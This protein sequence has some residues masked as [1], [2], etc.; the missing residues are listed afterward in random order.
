M[1]ALVLEDERHARSYL[2]ELIEATGLAHVNAAVATVALANA[3]LIDDQ[4]D[5]AFVDVRLVGTAAMDTAGL[6]WIEEIRRLASPPQIIVTTASSEHAVTAFELGAVDYLLK[7]FL[8]KRVA[9]SLERARSRHR[10][11]NLGV[12]RLRPRVV[13]RKGRGLVFLEPDEAWAFEAEGRLCYVHS[14]EGRFD[15]DLS[16]AALEAVLGESFL[17]VHR[18]WLVSLSHVRE[19]DRAD[20][21]PTLLL[22]ESATRRT[23]RVQVARERTTLVRERLLDSTVG[24]RRDE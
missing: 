8:Q 11:P 16:L 21:L 7:P 24:L 3:A 2:V 6:A 9:E 13:A 15:V 14:A 17:R 4:V 22:G 18:N 19:F 1:R 5:V 20:G 12:R 23:L 10:L